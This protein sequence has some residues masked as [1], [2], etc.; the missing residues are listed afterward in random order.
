VSGI[1]Q[2]MGLSNVEVR[3]ADIFDPSA[4]IDLVGQAD[5]TGAIEVVL[6]FP[7]SRKLEGMRRMSDLIKPGSPLSIV[8]S[9]IEKPLGAFAERYYANQSIYFGLREQYFQ[10]MRDSNLHP[11]TYVDYTRDMNQCFKETSVIL[12]RYRA[13]LRQEFGALMS[14]AWP[15][16]PATLYIQT[17]KNIR[18][19]HTVGIKH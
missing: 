12:R 6:H 13:Q 19:I 18:Y 7:T 8:D 14:L 2:E 11:V 10:F 1:V 17:L 15:E 3:R 4:T 9:S 16:I 5:A